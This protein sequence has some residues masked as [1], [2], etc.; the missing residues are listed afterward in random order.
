MLKTIRK[1]LKNIEEIIADVDAQIEHYLQQFRQEVE[2]LQSIPGVA[3]ETATCLIAEVGTDMSV[4]P[5]QKYLSSWAGMCPGNNVSA[6]KKKSEKTLRE[7][8]HSRL[9]LPKRHGL[10][11]IIKTA[12]YNE[13]IM[14]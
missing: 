6:G 12:I 9:L 5:D 7:I 3:R 13:N 10:H 14:A 11:L 4:F 2:L 1:S 8:R